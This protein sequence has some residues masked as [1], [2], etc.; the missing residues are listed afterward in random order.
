MATSDEARGLWLGVLGVV[1][2]SLTMPMTRLAVGGA[3]DPQ[4]PAAFVTAGRAGMA[5][6]LSAI[7]LFAT[8]AGRLRREH[9]PAMAI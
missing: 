8:R 5:S 6:L 4:L 7:Y 9:L 2:F 1:I 3:G